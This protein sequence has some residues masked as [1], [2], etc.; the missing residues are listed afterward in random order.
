MMVRL[1]RHWLVVAFAAALQVGIAAGAGAAPRAELWARWQVHDPA[2]STRIDHGA[3]AGFLARYVEASA[4]GINRVAYGRV[5]RQDR[6]ILDGYV[7]AL[8]ALPVSSLNRPQQMAYWINLYNALTVQLVLVHQPARSIRDIDISPGLFSDGPWGKKLVAVEGER[9]SLD[10][11]EHRILRPIW[12]DPRVHYAVN[13]ASL[14]CPD[15]QPEPF[16]AERLEEQLEQAARSYVNHPRGVAIVDG[17]LVVSSIYE[18][19]KE[20][21]GG[22]DA[23]VIAHLRRYAAPDLAAALARFAV[24]GDDRYDWHLN[25]AGRSVER[26]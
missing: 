2:S 3:W 13:C 19:F 24:I 12:R 17:E 1:H 20:D 15:L 9:L 11:I 25:D 4:D 22:T 6:A 14:G 5:T 7:A 10:D 26:S 8:A 21:F 23:G 16:L 18:W